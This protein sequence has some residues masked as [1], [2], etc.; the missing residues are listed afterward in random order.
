[1]WVGPR[2]QADLLQRLP[3]PG[4]ARVHKLDHRQPQDGDEESAA[5]GEGQRDEDAAAGP[6]ADDVGWLQA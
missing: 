6:T 2:W 1:M 5:A 3:S 4:V